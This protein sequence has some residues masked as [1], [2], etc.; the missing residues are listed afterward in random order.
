MAK[1]FYILCLCFWIGNF[2]F[3]QSN[4]PPEIQAVG[5]QYYCPLSQIPVTTSF[6]IVDPDDTEIEELSI[7]ISTGYVQGEDMLLLTGTHPNIVTFWSAAEGKL[8]L[9]GVANAPV[10]Y[11]DMIAAVNDVVFQSSSISFSGVKFFSFTIGDAN[12]LPS[13]G[14]YYEYITNIGI[15]WSDARD[16]AES[17]TYYGLQGYLA[18]I[19]T[20]AEAQICGEQASG[21]GWIGG[22]DEETEGVWKWMTG[23]EAGTIFWN[24]DENGSSPNYANWNTGE[25]NN[26][27]N[28]DYAHVTAPNI[29]VVGS[30]NDLDIDGDPNSTS[31]YHPQGFIVEY[32]GMPGDPVVN[33]STSTRISINEITSTFDATRCGEGTVNLEAFSFAGT[34]LWFDAPTGGNLL[35]SGNSFTTPNLTTTTNFY[36]LPSVNGC[37]EGIRQQVTATIL[38]MPMVQPSITLLNCDEDGVPDGFTDFNLTEVEEQIIVGDPSN[39][40]ITYHQSLTDADSGVNPINA[41]PYN[42]SNG[43]TIYARIDN[44]IGCYDVSTIDLQVST[45]SFTAGYIEELA[46]CD[47]DGTNDGLHEFDLTQM[48]QT[49]I[50]QFPSGQ[51]LSVQYYE[52]IEDAQLEQNEIQNLLNYVNTIP[53]SQTL[54]VR[55][56][57]DDNG[58]CFG[59][60]PHLLLTV[61]EVPEFEV[62]QQDIFCFD[63]NPILLETFNPNGNFSYEWTDESGALIGTT[64]QIETSNSGEISVTAMSEEGCVSEPVVF[65]LVES[66][67]ADIDLDDLIIEDFSD[68]NSITI[69]NSNNN[70]GIGD[71]EFA[72]FDING[73]YQDEPIFNNVPAGLFDLHVRDKNGCGVASLQVAVSG[74]PKFFTPNNDGFN[75]TWNLK[76]WRNQFTQESRIYIYDRYGK[77]I[78]QLAPWT[79][80]WNGTFNGY[81]LSTTDFWFV[82]ELVE[83]NGETRTLKGHFSLV[84]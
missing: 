31:D 63:G 40:T 27:G 5:D 30:W 15:T 9:G 56:E 3:S 66:A 19:L 7:Q 11:A 48:S 70:L 84:R 52:T 50:D 14:H 59:I 39:V 43:S 10:S 20:S 21:T 46:I 17:Y 33:I 71:Y 26:L 62:A 45:T 25:P 51:N 2:S 64:S 80:G 78:K 4:I 1:S 41:V 6:N 18:T 73:P 34:I 69:N 76:G 42:N 16:L 23:P 55:V 57:S 67:I 58:D 54:F 12:Y 29:G 35:G 28:E 79:N 77:L 24:G 83:Q 60:G 37:T 81:E 47:Y 44:S 22:S 49:F 68:N 82:A 61:R 8:S 38:E 74:F 72:L 13:T 53:F 32:G 75:D 36:A 65:N